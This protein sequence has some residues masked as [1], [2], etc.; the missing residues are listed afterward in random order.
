MTVIGVA[1]WRAKVVDKEMGYFLAL[2][3]LAL[4]LP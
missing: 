1:V 2:S 4:A 3:S